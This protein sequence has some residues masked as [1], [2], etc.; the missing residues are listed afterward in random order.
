M[1]KSFKYILINSTL[2]FVSAFIITTIFHEFGHYLAYLFFGSNPTM[3]HNF[4][5]ASDQTLNSSGQITVV[6]MGP[7]FSLLQ[8][9]V[10]GFIILKK[11]NTT[12][13]LL[14]LWL[15]LLGFVNFFGYL[16]MTPFSKTGDTGKVAELLNIDFILRI[17]IA[18]VG[19]FIL[20]WLIQRLAK[21]FSNFIPD[22]MD[23]AIKA[24]YIYQLMF[25]P[26]IIGSLINAL[27]AFPVVNILSVIYPAT[28]SYTI[29][30]SFRAILKSSTHHKTGPEF[31]KRIIK[32]LVVLVIAAIIINRLLTMGVG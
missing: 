29:M 27:L 21:N 23:K 15:S 7:I 28:S 30:S 14:I 25:F 1:E 20:L 8:G 18:A 24:K 9:F 17:A 6:L 16:V 4:V 5:Q 26:I 12:S 22:Q 19:L 2:A 11:R 13:Q 31:E 3:Y 10:L 32:S